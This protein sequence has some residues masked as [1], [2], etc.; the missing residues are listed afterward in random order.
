MK[1]SV[2]ISINPNVMNFTTHKIDSKV[3]F[4]HIIDYKGLQGV[5][6]FIF[7][8]SS[9]AT[10]FVVGV[11]VWFFFPTEKSFSTSLLTILQLARE[12]SFLWY[13]QYEQDEKCLF[14][15]F[16]WA[17]LQKEQGRLNGIL[18]SFFW[19]IFKYW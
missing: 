18:N 15:S 9:V 5:Q 14:M 4:E 6:Q 2:L 3:S 17:L 8:D 10:N 19:F 1:D 12:K 16:P 7:C 13:H 11:R